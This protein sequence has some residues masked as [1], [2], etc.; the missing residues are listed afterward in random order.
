MAKKKV[1]MMF[2][3]ESLG[4][5]ESE[6][7][8]RGYYYVPIKFY[9]DGNEGDS[10]I[11]YTLDWI[12]DNLNKDTDFKTSTSDIA[13]I[14]KEFERALE[15]AEHILYVPLTKH[16][17]SQGN[18]AKLA[19]EEAGLEDKITIYDSEFISPWVIAMEDKIH[20]LVQ[21]D[22]SLEEFMELFDKTRG[23]MFAWLFPNNLERLKASGRLS[24][25]AYM[26]GTLLKITPVTP[27]INGMLDPNGVVKARSKDKALDKIVDNTIE[28]Y[29]ELKE[30]GLKA[31]ILI[32]VLG[33]AEENEHLDS[34]RAKFAEKGVPEV[35]LTWI[36]AAVVGHVG[37]G[38]I[39]AGVAI[40]PE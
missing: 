24:K 16:F 33:R 36:S 39:G 23:N 13:S 5:S 26:A 21:E 27:V 30:K 10:G 29:N 2:D 4:L 37:L 15:D 25:A 12:Y 19:A 9:I 8:A 14:I 11:D 17:T 20:S 35:P 28:K 32:A 6:A 3:S 18:A 7:R 38:G 40:D 1:A 22:A 31:R 34:I